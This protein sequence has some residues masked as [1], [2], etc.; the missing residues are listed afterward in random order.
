M[1]S[2]AWLADTAD[3]P[4][5]TGIV[6]QPGDTLAGRTLSAEEI[7][8]TA[9]GFLLEVPTV[10]KSA[11]GRVVESMV[12]PVA[13][14]MTDVTG[15]RHAIPA[16]AWVLTART[17]DQAVLHD[18]RAGR[19]SFQ[20]VL[21]SD[22]A[23]GHPVTAQ[24][25]KQERVIMPT[26]Y[27]EIRKAATA[28]HP[29]KSEAQAVT[30]Y[31]DDHPDAYQRYRESRQPSRV[32]KSYGER[33]I[34]SR[35]A[36]LVR[37]AQ[38]ADPSLNEPAAVAVV[39]RSTEGKTLYRD[40]RHAQAEASAPPSD[41]MKRDANAVLQRLIEAE[42]RRS[43]VTK[44]QATLAVT[45]SEPGATAWRILKGDPERIKPQVPVNK[46]ADIFST[47]ERLGYDIRRSNPKL[48][49]EQAITKA[50]EQHP[51]LYKLYRKAL[52]GIG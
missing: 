8:R 24:I 28:A 45:S 34:E 49:R 20:P 26:T 14:S 35:I 33:V 29:D 44:A 37:K 47:F 15:R 10:A 12:A 7:E 13:M 39:L 5:I 50:A 32:Q 51:D 48:T 31:V 27:E 25:R 41:V 11:G 40:L 2:P 19:F 1:S 4:L 30:A 9:H 18:V 21:A 16:G 43:G 17:D 46:S 52:L 6:L 36:E 38:D 3:M 42:V 23:N 22:A